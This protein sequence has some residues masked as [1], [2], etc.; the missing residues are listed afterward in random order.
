MTFK[1]SHRVSAIKGIAIETIDPN[2]T[3]PS[4]HITTTGKDSLSYFRKVHL[5]RGLTSMSITFKRAA[6]E[7]A[8]K[9]GESQ[10]RKASY[11]QQLK[12]NR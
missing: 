5:K 8:V 1:K 10:Q 12:H 3:R 11:F 6:S 4:C 7:L 2:R 9:I